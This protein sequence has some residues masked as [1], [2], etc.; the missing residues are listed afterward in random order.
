MQTLVGAAFAGVALRLTRLYG[1]KE[2][3]VSSG[4]LLSVVLRMM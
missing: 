3:S 2:P 4:Y 1:F